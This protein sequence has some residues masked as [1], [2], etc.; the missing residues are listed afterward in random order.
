MLRPS[1]ALSALACLV[2]ACARPAPSAAPAA[3]TDCDTQDQ[4][5]SKSAPAPRDRVAEIDA[6]G[7]RARELFEVP[8]LALA[9]VHEGEVVIAK[10]Y[11]ERVLGGGE[12]VDAQTNFAIASNS[13][14]FTAT[15]VGLLVADG[16]VGWDDRVVDHLPDLVLWNDYVTRELRVRDL[17]SHRVGLRT[18]EGDLMW[19]SSKFS[20]T[21]IYARLRYL[22]PPAG[23]RERYGYCNLMFAVA[24]ELIRAKSGQTWEQFV[25]ARLLEPLGMSQA[26]TTLEGALGVANRAEPHI[27][28]EGEWQTTPRL[29]LSAMAAAA[30]IDASVEDMAKWMQMQLANGQLGG[31]Q[32][33]PAKIIEQTH[34]PHIWLETPSED[35]YEPARHLRG[36]GLGWFLEDYRGRTLVHHGGGL[37]GMTSRVLLVPDE[38]L[39]VVILTN[40]ESPVSRLLAFQ[41]ADLFLTDEPGKDYLAAHLAKQAEAEAARAASESPKPNAKRAPIPAGLEGKYE[42]PLLGL[43]EIRSEDGGLVFEA[44]EHGGLR[45]RFASEAVLPEGAGSPVSVELP[46]TWDDP[47]MGISEFGLVTKGKRVRELRFSVRPSFYD[48]LEYSFARA[49]S[50]G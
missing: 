10:G 29:D 30:A 39:G 13:K 37:P 50:Q 14:A 24:G 2:L 23:L 44:T 42:S 7:E 34:Q 35:F 48:P 25:A 9:V 36:Y 41:I 27:Q 19:I 6:L 18:W 11:G 15:A 5:L 47:N 3:S 33:V 38:A 32:V 22:D 21:D 17:L 40:S 26:Q 8:G 28:I 45:C 12:A 49:R 16:L 31:T 46:C 4:P 1:L 43:A 20:F